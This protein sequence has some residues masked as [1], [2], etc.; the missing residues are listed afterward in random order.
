MSDEL[1]QNPTIEPAKSSR[2]SCRI[3]QK[4]IEKGAIRI[5]VPSPYTLP[6][7]RT[8][9]SYRYYHPDCVPYDSV[10]AILDILDFVTTIYPEDKNQVKKSLEKIQMQGSSTARGRRRV[11]TESF[12]EYSRSGR[13]TCRICENKIEKGIFRVAEPTQIE[14]TNG[15]RIF[16]QKLYHID[17]FLSSSAN[18][19][20]AFQNLMEVSI[21]GKKLSEEQLENL[22]E[23]FQMYLSGTET[24]YNVLELI[25]EKPV[26]I[27]TL[28]KFAEEKGVPFKIV[29]QAIEE[30]LIKG[31][32]FQPSPKTIQKM[33]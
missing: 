14:L 7:G 16:G 23:N 30:G 22:K 19:K 8:V 11:I 1:T 31:E 15:R 26:K 21:Q 6:D 10:A 32:Y 13:G 29:E 20:R 3:C 2:S 24:A 12:F 27:D 9:A 4:K 17:C 25:G 18:P 33:D 28:K 5:G